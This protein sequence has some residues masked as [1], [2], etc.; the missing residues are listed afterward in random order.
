MKASAEP[1]RPNAV[2]SRRHSQSVRRFFAEPDRYLGNDSRLMVRRLL[3]GQMVEA[4]DRS[5]ILDMG[6]GDGSMS[7]PLLAPE[8]RLTLLDSSAPMLERAKRNI[9]RRLESSV[10]TVCQDL[11]EFAPTERYTLVLCLGVLAHVP[12]VGEALAKIASLVRSGG[13]CLLHITDA[14]RWLGRI[15]YAYYGWRS[16]VRPSHG[17][18]LNRLKSGKLV[19]DADALGLRLVE[20]RNYSLTFPGLRRLPNA[21]QFRLERRFLNSRFSRHGGES[22]SLFQRR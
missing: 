20:C 8:C 14:S 1:D 22:L 16:R 5:L 9:P 21:L 17:Y 18:P 19:A 12:D 6:C 10:E 11:M 4:V 7:L 15:N 3:C 2:A 13:H